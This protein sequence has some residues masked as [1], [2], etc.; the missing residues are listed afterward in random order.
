MR[1]RAEF[2]SI[3]WSGTDSPLCM[4]QI[5]EGYVGT[6]H[7]LVQFT[8]GAD[9]LIHDAQ[10]LGGSLSWP[11]GRLS[12]YAG[13]RALDRDDGLRGGGAA[14]VGKLVLFHHEPAYTDGVI[15]KSSA[16]RRSSLQEYTGGVRG[17][18]AYTY[19]FSR[20][21]WKR[22]AESNRRERWMYNMLKMAED[23]IK[24]IPATCWRTSSYL[25]G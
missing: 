12:V 14:G 19:F 25:K 17:V 7:R 4:P 2:I 23:Q 16:R 9:V 1:T 22:A 15:G 24:M 11:T 8:R 13:L 21:R 20:Q 5:L 3:V 18:G 6:D 10:Y